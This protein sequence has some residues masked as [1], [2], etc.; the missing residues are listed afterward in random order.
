MAQGSRS[1]ILKH[2]G[3][4]LVRIM[5]NSKITLNSLAQ[6]LYS[7]DIIDMT[8][9]N[10]AMTK[11]G[12]EGANILLNNMVMKI[13]ENEKHLETILQVLPSAKDS[14][15]SDRVQRIK[16]GKCMHVRYYDVNRILI[17]YAEAKRDCKPPPSPGILYL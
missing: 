2:H 9:K 13:D 14:L 6:E 10:E 16:K 15:L 8:T 12:Q 11:G 5:A 3:K 17:E 1:S 4:D 7:A